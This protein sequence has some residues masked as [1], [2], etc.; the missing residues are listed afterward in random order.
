MS[1]G[2]FDGVQFSL[3]MQLSNVGCSCVFFFDLQESKLP[4]APLTHGLHGLPSS[5]ESNES[6]YRPQSK[7]V[8]KFCNSSVATPKFDR[9]KDFVPSEEFE[10]QFLLFFHFISELLDFSEPLKKHVLFAQ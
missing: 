7:H 4:D 9:M 2:Y 1:Y 10:I 5:N 8:E 6:N 3:V